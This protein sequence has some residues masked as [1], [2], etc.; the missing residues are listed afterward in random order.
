MTGK[1]S[2]EKAGEDSSHESIGEAPIE[3]EC[4]FHDHPL[5]PEEME[6]YSPI[7]DFHSENDIANYV[8]GQASGE[9]V[10]HVEKIKTEYVLGDA[11]EIW[12]VTT[13]QDRWWVLTNMTNLYSQ[14]LFPSMDYTLSFHIGLMMRLR[15]NNQRPD[16][17]DPFDEV[18]RR[19]NQAGDK[20]EKG[21]EVEDYQ[22]VGMQLR[23]ALLSL[24]S[25]MRRRVEIETADEQPKEADFKLWSELIIGQLCAGAQ[26]KTLRQYLKTA[27]EKTWQLVNWL[28]HNRNANKTV[29]SIALRA[30]GSLFES[31]LELLIRSK[32][33]GSDTCPRCASKDI[34]SHFDIYIE[35]DGEY[36]QT[37]GSCGW[38]SHPNWEKD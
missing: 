28:T 24:I 33:D 12:D 29:S 19:L 11:Y 20:H 6:R 14:R 22:S 30:C 36:Y 5:P 25:L 7:R 34:R 27:S 35:P 13:D 18:I 16:S 1:N 2:N 9:L 8:Q 21:I 4:V 37:C 15:S 26:N 17:S 38:S 3:G 32:F 23:E 10:K 31:Y